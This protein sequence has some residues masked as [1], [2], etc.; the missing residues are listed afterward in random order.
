M[1]VLLINASDA[2]A[3]GAA[4]AIHRLGG[5][6]VTTDSYG[7][8]LHIATTRHID[9]VIAADPSSQPPPGEVDL[10]ALGSVLSQKGI[11]LLTVGDSTPASPIERRVWIGSI[12]A[13]I[14]AD[15]L[16]GRLATI[17]T[18]HTVVK[19]LECELRTLDLL[20]TRL[21]EHF[22]E[23]DQELQLAS[24]LQRDF[25]PDPAVSLPNVRF[26]AAY[27]PASWVS[28]DMYDVYRVDEHRVGY[29]L[30]DAVGH[31]TAAGLLTM[32]IKQAVA[33][34]RV[35]DD[36][37]RVLT[38]SETLQGLNDALVNQGL[39]NC[40]FV[41]ACCGLL[42]TETLTLSYARGGHPYPI[43]ISRDGKLSTLESDGGLLGLV[44]DAAF[45]AGSV[46]LQPGE[47]VLLY[48]DGVETAFHAGAGAGIDTTAYLSVF[49][50]VAH[51]PAPEMIAEIERAM[52][53]EQG[54]IAP[55]DDV[56]ILAIEV[57]EQ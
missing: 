10:A 41:T 27:R 17:A 25:L 32:F 40:R 2:L 35:F 7:D 18:Y 24:R 31:G 52:N 51:L 16:K 26:A 14:T 3:A 48:S 29:Y 30:A 6:T 23:V 36:S 11:A 37:Y 47:K 43:H 56:T 42:D 38:P 19:D 13:D 34:K 54:S 46:Q 9:T 20:S 22:H 44:G 8:A 21:K 15:E 53:T 1:Q 12:D 49:E 55:H 28:G 39:P 33:T 50:S 57:T 5:A 45:P 4:E